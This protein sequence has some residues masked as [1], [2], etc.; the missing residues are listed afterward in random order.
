MPRA[1]GILTVTTG[2]MIFVW[3]YAWAVFTTSSLL[4]RTLPLFACAMTFCAAFAVTRLLGQ[5][6]LYVIAVGGVHLLSLSVGV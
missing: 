3:L 1:K 4:P 2:C 6:G 5:R